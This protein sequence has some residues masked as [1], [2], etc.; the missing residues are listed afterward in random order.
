[1]SILAGITAG[2]IGKFGLGAAGVGFGL[3]NNRK[4]TQRHNQAMDFAERQFAHSTRPMSD[5]VQ[6]LKDAGL[7][8]SLA[9]GGGFSGGQPAGSAPGAG[10]DQ[11]VMEQALMSQQML[12]MAAET[13]KTRAE[14][15]NIDANTAL[16]NQEF[17]ADL[18]SMTAKEIAQR[19]KESEANVK[20]VNEQANWLREQISTSEW[21][22]EQAKQLWE[23][24]KARLEHNL[25]RLQAS[26]MHENQLAT[27]VGKIRTI[28]HDLTRN[29]SGITPQQLEELDDS[30]KKLMERIER[31]QDNPLDRWWNRQIDKFR[32]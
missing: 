19:M 20:T 1:M 5:Q 11:S 17:K 23:I 22:T 8:P 6:E 18:P 24:E 16:Q 14:K 9:V 15:E 4:N 7:H 28:L 13:D 21:N 2:G 27:E 32:R 26:G 29:P 30:Q 3:W 12:Q 10:R 25:E 31:M